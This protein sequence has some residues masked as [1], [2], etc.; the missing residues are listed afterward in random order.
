MN[1]REARNGTKLWSFFGIFLKIAIA[2][3]FLFAGAT[4]V[5]DPGDFAREI[6]RYQIVP[7]TISA[8]GA[9]YLPWLEM[10]V[11]ALLLTRKFERGSLLIIGTL[12]LLFTGALFS[13][14]WRG[15]NIDCGCFGKAF[16]ST[17]TFGP[18]IRNL[19]LMIGV[20]VLWRAGLSRRDR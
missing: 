10:M 17:G 3:L 11:G 4:K 18:L 8:F 9:T 20:W 7:W 12:L 1:F 5:A 14:L 13:A 19:V 2:L 16:A 15:L 6:A